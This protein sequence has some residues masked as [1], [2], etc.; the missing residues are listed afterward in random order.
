M[1]CG[2]TLKH[3][4]YMCLEWRSFLF[5]FRHSHYKLLIF[6]SQRAD[7]S[8]YANLQTQRMPFTFTT[9]LSE[10]CVNGVA[11][12]TP[13]RLIHLF[14]KSLQ[15]ICSHAQ[16]MK[17]MNHLVKVQ[18]IISTYGT[19]ISCREKKSIVM[20]LPHHYAKMTSKLEA[21]RLL[22]PYREKIP[23]PYYLEYC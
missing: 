3:T 7:H 22:S 1:L 5:W 21:F 16:T 12:A 2:L 20:D 19:C 8:Q 10:T 14:E 4:N 6:L 15:C 11:T 17:L 18:A 23:C 13:E 9:I